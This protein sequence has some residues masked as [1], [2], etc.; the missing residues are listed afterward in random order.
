M[1][2]TVVKT[3]L[4]SLERCPTYFQKDPAA[5]Y[6]CES[7]PFR[8]KCVQGC[9]SS[10]HH[11]ARCST[12][13]QAESYGYDIS[14][15]KLNSWSTLINCCGLITW[16]AWKSC[17]TW[18]NIVVKHC[19]VPMWPWWKGK[20]CCLNTKK[21]KKGLFLSFECIQLNKG[22]HSISFSDL[23]PL[24]PVDLGL[25]ANWSQCCPIWEWSRLLRSLICLVWWALAEVIQPLNL[26]A[27]LSN[28][29]ANTH[30]PSALGLIFKHLEKTGPSVYA[31]IFLHI[32][33]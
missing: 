17:I 32:C 7:K 29:W 18:Q 13:Q 26:S 12:M 5:N 1:S 31:S 28:S 19:E 24:P 15:C 14:V 22:D 20:E 4:E 11:S 30:S 10:C 6:L 23:H 9:S 2:S 8:S 3:F 25:K 21:R 33:T 27:Y 16:R